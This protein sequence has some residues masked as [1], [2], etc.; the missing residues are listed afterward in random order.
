MA[1]LAQNVAPAMVSRDDKWV[2]MQGR[3]LVG[4]EPELTALTELVEDADAGR[5]R[6]ALVTGEAGIGKTS[7]T[8]AVEAVAREARFDV[9]WGRCSSVEMPPYWPWTQALNTLLGAADL[10][11]PGRFASRPELSAA[12]AEAIEACTRVARRAGDLRGRA[13][14][15]SRLARSAGVPGRDGRRPAAL[16]TDHLSGRRRNTC[17]HRRRPAYLLVRSRPRGDVGSCPADRRCANRARNTSPRSIGAVA[18]IRSSPPRSPGCRPVV[19]RRRG[20]FRWGCDRFSS[21]GSPGCARSPS[22][23]SGWPAW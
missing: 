22:T 4:R 21:T 12:V 20:R 17:Q 13:L 2:V 9:A 3:S 8:E 6:V 18:A 11:D 15:R 1:S 23:C 7:L 16:A 19:G 5:G 10:L 14:G